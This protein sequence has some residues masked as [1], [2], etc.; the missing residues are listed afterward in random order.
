MGKPWSEV[1]TLATSALRIS[2]FQVLD[3]D[4]E[5]VAMSLGADTNALSSNGSSQCPTSGPSI[6]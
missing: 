3:E 2:P 4:I 5:A 6:I 1:A